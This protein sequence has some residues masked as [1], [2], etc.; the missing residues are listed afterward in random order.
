MVRMPQQ[1]MGIPINIETR[2]S[3]GDFQQVGILSK[4]TI[5]EDGKTPG[6]NTDSNVLPLYGKPIYRGASRWLYYTETD[7]FNPI[8][9]PITVSGRD[10]TDD[11]GCEELY[12]GSDVVIPS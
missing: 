12:D 8:K 5:D 10:C 9:I 1:Q 7:K 6:N 4:Q 2:G 11:Q 3:G